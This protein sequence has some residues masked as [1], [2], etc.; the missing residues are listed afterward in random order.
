MKKGGYSMAINIQNTKQWCKENSV[1]LNL[2]Y[3][4]VFSKTMHDFFTNK[5]KHSRVKTIAKTIKIG[6]PVSFRPNIKCKEDL[7]MN[8]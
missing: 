4:S 2:H 6:L 8:N 7:I 1:S 3:M 5:A